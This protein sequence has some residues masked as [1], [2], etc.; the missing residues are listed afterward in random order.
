MESNNHTETVEPTES[1]SEICSIC[2][3]N[4]SSN[5][6]KLNCGHIFHNKCIITWLKQSQTCPY[7]REN[8]NFSLIEYT[9]N[10]SN[11]KYKM[12]FKERTSISLNSNTISFIEGLKIQYPR[13]WL[14]NKNLYPLYVIN[15]NGKDT[16]ISAFLRIKLIFSNLSNISALTCKDFNNVEYFDTDTDLIYNNIN[17]SKK[18]FITIY[19]WVYELMSELSEKYNFT[20]NLA[21]NTIIIDL[22]ITTIITHNVSDKNLYQG[23]VIS[24]VYNSIKFIN[25]EVILTMHDLN[26]YTTYLYNI[27]DLVPYK[28]SQENIIKENF[29]K[30]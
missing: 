29:I 6:I 20:F 28:T 12:K 5:T 15:Y 8:I 19:E 16:Y 7:C 11:S 25:P 9:N 14:N 3:D 2:Y 1:T 13:A 30:I 23:I 22:L 26:Y 4:A 10:T 27:W 21:Y 17:I 18:V 24:S